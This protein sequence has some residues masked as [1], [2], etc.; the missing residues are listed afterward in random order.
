MDYQNYRDLHSFYY[1]KPVWMDIHRCWHS[2]FQWEELHVKWIGN[3]RWWGPTLLPA[4]CLQILLHWVSPFPVYPSKQVQVIVRRGRVSYTLHTA[5][6]A[7]GL[8]AAQGF[9]HLF[10]CP[11]VLKQAS[12]LG[13][14]PS[15]SHPPS[16]T[17]GSGTVVKK[18]IAKCVKMNHTYWLGFSYLADSLQSMDLLWNLGDRYKFPCDL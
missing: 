10:V 8:I 16:S 2:Q 4:N 5:F 12:W 11:L 9:L 6:C 14:S 18:E 1:G 3:F 13:H 15:W 17:T 7:Q